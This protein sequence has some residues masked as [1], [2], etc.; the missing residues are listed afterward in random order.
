MEVAAI[1]DSKENLEKT[2]RALRELTGREVSQQEAFEFAVAIQTAHESTE[3]D[4]VD[5]FDKVQDK[6]LAIGP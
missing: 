3:W 6:K 5:M 1:K 4:G 2:L